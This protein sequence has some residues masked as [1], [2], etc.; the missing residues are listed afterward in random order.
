M[1]KLTLRIKTQAQ[2]DALVKQLAALTD[3]ERII[4]FLYQAAEQIRAEN[5]SDA[6]AKKEM[7][8][9]PPSVTPAQLE[10]IKA[11][12]EQGLSLRKIAKKVKLAH[13]TVDRALK[14]TNKKAAADHTSTN[15]LI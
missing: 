13:T 15:D 14:G 11:L 2:L 9:R 1:R 6:I 8:G 12:N 7:W 4:P 3:P 10:K 5:I